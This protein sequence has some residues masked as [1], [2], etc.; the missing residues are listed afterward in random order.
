MDDT[1]QLLMFHAAGDRAAMTQLLERHQEFLRRV[2]RLRFDAQLQ[3]RI[4]LSDVV[5][6]THLEI[7][8]RLDDFVKRRPMSFRV[9]LHETA[10]QKLLMIHRRHRRAQCRSIDREVSLPEDSS[11][12]LAEQLVAESPGQMAQRAELIDR[13]RKALDQLADADRE[14][15]LLRNFD[16]LTNHEASERLGIQPVAASKRYGRA[17]L[18]LRQH[19]APQ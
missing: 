6:E 9:W 8:E 2:L 3:G 11:I 10:C 13:V 4:D 16:E 14:I 5:Q 19:L 1:Q 12:M 15:I 7:I 18:R 17:L